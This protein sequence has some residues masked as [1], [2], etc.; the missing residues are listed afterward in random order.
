[1][2]ELINILKVAIIGGSKGLGNFIL[3]DI[4]FGPVLPAFLIAGGVRQFIPR[5]FL[6]NLI[7]EQSSKFKSYIVSSL[8]GVVFAGCACGVLPLFVSLCEKGSN[9]GPAITFLFAGPALNLLAIVL[10]FQFFGAKMAIFRT[11]FAIG[12]AIIIGLIL[13]KIFGASPKLPQEKESCPVNI[14][15]KKPLF[16][17]ILFF[18]SLFILMAIQV[19]KN[20]LNKFY[21]FAL[22][23]WL[24]LFILFSY[25]FFTKEEI[26]KWLKGTAHYFRRI[27]IPLLIGIFIVEFLTSLPL[28]AWK[29]SVSDF[30]S[31]SNLLTNSLASIL[32]AIMYFGTCVGVVIVKGFMGFGMHEGP[33]MALFIAGPAVSFPSFLAMRNILGTKITVIYVLIVIITGICSGF[34]Y[35]NVLFNYF[36]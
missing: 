4:L 11:L 3:K 15:L 30:L 35:G 19:N 27:A 34:L 7:G 14:V 9:F 6:G 18:V 1:M 25:Y 24:A 21:K 13:E 23:G 31:K 8:V 36:R 16:T 22:A 32:A 10:T 20:V 5:S 33:A 28:P 17:L 2:N 12:F 26:I 29:A